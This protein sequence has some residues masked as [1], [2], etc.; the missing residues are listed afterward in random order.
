METEN[1]Y[2]NTTVKQILERKGYKVWSLAPDTTVFDALQ[3]LAKK[4]I[5]AVVVL[6]DEVPVGIFSERD[7][8]RKVHL[9]DRDERT[10]RLAEV[11]TRQVIGVTPDTEVSVCSALMTN[12]FIR[13]LPVV[14]ADHKIV[15]VISIGDVVKELIAEQE[16]VIDQLVNYISGEQ[17]KPPVPEPTNV[18][19]P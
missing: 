14:D 2:T 17:E 19:L 10:T 11:M 8:A 6:Q 9:K 15:G 16:F 12:K 7:Y 18:E 4:N 3:F 1:M 5:G 13:H